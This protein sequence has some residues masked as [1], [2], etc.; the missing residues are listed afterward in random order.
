MWSV[1]LGHLFASWFQNCFWFCVLTDGS[2]PYLF[3]QSNLNLLSKFWN[4]KKCSKWP[5]EYII[6]GPYICNI[7]QLCSP[8]I[9]SAANLTMLGICKVKIRIVPWCLV[10]NL[11][12]FVCF[13]L[14]L[15]LR[16]LKHF[17][18]DVSFQ[19]EEDL[20]MQIKWNPKE[21]LT[22]SEFLVFLHWHLCFLY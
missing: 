18:G 9:L 20:S 22:L 13:T 12:N 4:R 1:C 8:A 16:G 19:F 11:A 14:F 7:I 10:Y 5:L 3:L 15:L 2:W 17:E 21:S 6:F